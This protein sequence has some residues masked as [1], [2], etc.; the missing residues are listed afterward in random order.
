LPD[1]A[2]EPHREIVVRMTHKEAVRWLA[3]RPSLEQMRTRCPEDWAAVEHDLA[4]ALA[5][6]SNE[7]LDRLLLRGV[8]GA[9]TSKTKRWAPG[10][11]PLLATRQLVRKRMTLLA[12]ERVSIGA[13]SGVGGDEMRYGRRTRI[14]TSLIFQDR[15]G[16]R[17]VVS[18]RFFRFLWPLVP[19]KAR[20]LLAAQTRGSYCFFSD[21]LIGELKHL[22]GGRR[23]IEIAAGDGTLSRLLRDRGVG[24]E[25]SD[26]R[27]WHH[28]IDYPPFVAGMDAETALRE[29]APEVVVC[30][31]PPA[32]NGFEH[33]VFESRSVVRYIVLGS[34]HDFASGAW[35]AYAGQR[36]FVMRQDAGLSALVLPPEAGTVVRIFDRIPAQANV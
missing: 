27:S 17:K 21:R 10:Q 22:I 4:E 32:A 7:A 35:D 30:C 1:E 29:L 11:A 20:F 25:A 26:D 23:V 19:E 9:R 12:L 36:G 33:A 8:A 6:K 24:I 3:D 5:R 34:V 15:L 16:D 31:W 14:L 18:S 28:A 2:V 13:A